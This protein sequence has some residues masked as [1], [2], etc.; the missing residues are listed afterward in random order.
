MLILCSLAL[1]LLVGCVCRTNAD[2]VPANPKLGVQYACVQGKCVEKPLGN[3]ATEF[4]LQNGGLVDMR[5]SEAGEYGVCIFQDGSECDEWAFFRGEC[6][7]GQSLRPVVSE[8]LPPQIDWIS[9]AQY[10]VP[11]KICTPEYAPVCAKIEMSSG[12]RWITFQNPCLAC[13]VAQRPAT[14]ITFRSGA[15]ETQ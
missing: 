8:E 13:K 4:C 11:G 9:C 3:P 15:C 2:C 10:N 1:V 14:T 12:T 7:P 6:Y 5:Q